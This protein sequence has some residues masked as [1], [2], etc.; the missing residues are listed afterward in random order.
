MQETI[1]LIAEKIDLDK[2]ENL[3]KF[4]VKSIKVSE[5]SGKRTTATYDNVLFKLGVFLE[6]LGKCLNNIP[7]AKRLTI[8][9]DALVITLEELGFEID[10]EDAFIIYHLRDLGKFKIRDAK[11]KED[12]KGAWG[13]HKDYAL[14][15]QE[16]SRT[17]KVLMRM[18]LID[19]RK[20]NLTLKKEMIIRYKG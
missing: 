9:V 17:L 15:D 1:Q 18:G 8:G 4:L 14:T 2:K 12:L 20:G 3:V 10:K 6:G 16:F 11:L 7:A 19:Y 13:E 5:D